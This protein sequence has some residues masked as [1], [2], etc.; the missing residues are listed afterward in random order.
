[1]KN[2]LTYS[3]IGLT[4]SI[5]AHAA[6][7]QTQAA[8]PTTTPSATRTA[9]PAFTHPGEVSADLAHI[10]AALNS[11]KSFSGRFAQYGSDGSFMSGQIFLKRPG[12]IRFEYDAPAPLLMV[13]D[14]VTLTQIDRQLET[15]DRVPLKATPL[16]FFLAETV[17]L[18][19]DVEITSLQKTA[20]SVRV[21]ARDGS[22][23]VEGAITMVFDPQ[24]LALSEW[25]IHD[26]FG[27]QTRI[28]LSE[29]AYNQKI[30]PRKF[31]LR[32]EPRG[33]R[34]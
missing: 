25:I 12:K 1:M 33:R 30:N 17:N 16:A 22:G 24:T 29:L 19:N 2:I 27:Q 9:L 26:S 7:A 20:N 15:K 31:I 23:E 18:E 10:D 8:T 5:G 14:G 21:T 11:T 6:L 13:S 4:L 28:I 3:L 34:K 32:D